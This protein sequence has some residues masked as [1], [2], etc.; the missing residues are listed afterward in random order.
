MMA[1]RAA[2]AGQRWNN[3]GGTNGHFTVLAN[4][5]NCPPDIAAEAFFALGDTLKQLTADPARPLERFNAALGAYA[6]IPQLFP[7]SHLVPEA[8]GMIGS[9]YLQLASASIGGDPKFY[10]NA[11]DAYRRVATN[12]LADAA[13]RSQAGIGLGQVLE[14]QAQTRPISESTNLLEAAFNH[15]YDIVSEKNLQPGEKPDPFWFKEAGMA[16]ARLAELRQRWQIAAHIY[17]R[18]IRELPP[19]REALQAR[20]E[21]AQEQLRLQKN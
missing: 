20:L 7:A 1:G 14:K 17:E 18:M 4:D 3:A 9:C 21:K 12:A 10:D 5:A 13:V 8:W 2:F 6:K 15:Y 19:M 11:L 16:A